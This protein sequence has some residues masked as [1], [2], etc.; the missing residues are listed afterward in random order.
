MSLGVPLAVSNTEVF[1]EVYD[2]GAIYFD[3]NDPEDIAQK[4]SLIYRDEKYRQLIANNAYARAQFFSWKKAA[5]ETL[6]VYQE[7][8]R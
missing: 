1:N 3:P 7:A 6:E 8:L 2:N 5:A 4:I